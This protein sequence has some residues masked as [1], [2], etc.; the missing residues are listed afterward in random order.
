MLLMRALLLLLLLLLVE[1][2]LF[3][4]SLLELLLQLVLLFVLLVVVMA[5]VC[6]FARLCP[7]L[8]PRMCLFLCPCPCLPLIPPHRIRRR[9]LWRWRRWGLQSGVWPRS[10]VGA[11]GGAS[12]RGVRVVAIPV[13]H[14]TS[15]AHS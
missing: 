3:V 8:C 15:H 2:S 14:A 1:I 5:L 7:R 9:Q 11:R 13:A 12:T 4:L 10:S 6:F